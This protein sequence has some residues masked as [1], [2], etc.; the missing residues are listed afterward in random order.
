MAGRFVNPY[1]QFSDSTPAMYSGAKL[2]FY[3][4]GTSTKLN[5]YSDRTL[6]S[7]NTN[8]V[9]LNS[10]GRPAVEIWL[11]DLDYKVVL[12]PSTDTDPP[13]SPIWSSDYVRARDSALIAKTIT[14]SGSPNGSVAGTAG[15]ASILPDFYW[16]YTSSYLYVCTTTGTSSTAVW[17]AVNASAATPAVPPPQG[18]LTLTSDTPV[19]VADVASATAVY[20]TPYVGNL[21]PIY[22][23]S[24][25]VPTEFAELTL[26]LH[27]NHA[28]NTLYDVFAFSNSGVLT[29][30]TGPAWSTS[31][32]GSG[33]RGTG[34]SST[35]LTR[36]KGLWVNAVAMTTRNGS[37]T[38]NVGANLGTY[39]GTVWIDGSA[40]QISCHVSWGSSRK[41]GV[42]NAYNREIVS[43]QAGDG[44]ANWNNA[45]A[46][47]RVSN[48]TSTN[49]VSLVM[50][51]PI[52][53][54]SITNTQR[55]TIA[56]DTLSS[57]EQAAT[58]GIGINSTTAFSGTQ[59]VVSADSN[60]MGTVVAAVGAT[61]TATHAMQPAIGAHNIYSLEKGNSAT[62]VVVLFWGTQGYHTLKAVYRA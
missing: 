38:Y 27:A 51:L 53:Q 21:V 56:P 12:A 6:S 1:P 25:M 33:A 58:V 18:R 14:G 62:S 59:G 42:W 35:Q 57:V 54:V 15:S 36:I 39:V 28:A 16:D 41:W 8:P 48:G 26:T 45:S 32:A 46:T 55:M 19:I 49:N 31:T 13:T 20:Y 52:D 44:T 5:T 47:V 61:A 37:T 2:F 50:G 9:V 34:A 60:A 43:T 30:V 22:N 4:A 17:T 3:A 10:A 24:S 40:G 29:L 11:Q 7:A 23:G